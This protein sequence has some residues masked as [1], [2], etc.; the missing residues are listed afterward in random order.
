MRKAS[1][2]AEGDVEMSAPSKLL[3]RMRFSTESFAPEHRFEAWCDLIGKTHDI[4]ADPLDFEARLQ[5]VAVGP[6]LVG[7]MHASPQIV[8]RLPRR[9]RS[10]GQDHLVLH[11]TTTPFT[12]ETSGGT[13]EVAAG[14]VTVNTLARP[15]QRSRAAEQ[16]SVVISLARNVVTEAVP[17]PEHFHGAVLDR[18]PGRLL[19]DLM[20]G[21]SRSAGEIAP[22]QAQAVADS[23]VRLLAA[24]LDPLPRTVAEA[25]DA[26]GAA[27]FLQCK[28]YIEQHL[29]SPALSPDSMCRALGISR[30]A[31][32]RLFERS[33]GVTSYI[34]DRRLNAARTTL[35][36]GEIRRVSE[37]A[38]RF[39]FASD[40]ALRRA[41]RAA[42]GMNPSEVTQVQRLVPPEAETSLFAGWLASFG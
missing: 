16:G 33:G 12:F 22:A 4:A 6:M 36:R 11:L 26:I 32:Y 25:A 28:R 40:T 1:S 23:T 34:R 42:F 24:A 9:L 14:S 5:S 30:S 15:F 17:D 29:G 39:G 41:Y 21:L 31:L 19:A 37:L 38:R 2:G 27:T 8:A 20:A 3:P 7:V 13:R 10:D 35:E 18:G